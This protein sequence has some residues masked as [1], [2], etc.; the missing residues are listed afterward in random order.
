MSEADRAF[1]AD[2]IVAWTRLG[3]NFRVLVG[4]FSVLAFGCVGALIF[5]GDLPLILMIPVV[6]LLVLTLAQAAMSGFAAVDCDEW[7]QDWS[8]VAE[9]A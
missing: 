9:S 4:R 6:V 5:G 3:D 2:R 1:V 7:V 8:I